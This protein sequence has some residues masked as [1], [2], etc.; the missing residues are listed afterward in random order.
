MYKRRGAASVCLFGGQ[1]KPRMS[2]FGLAPRPEISM[3]LRWYELDPVCLIANV[4]VPLMKRGL[5]TPSAV[6]TR[7]SG[8]VDL[9]GKLPTVPTPAGDC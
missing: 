7:S 6:L 5:D 3:I 4:F 9:G 1:Y 2:K 8:L